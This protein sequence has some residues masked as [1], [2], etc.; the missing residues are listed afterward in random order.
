M[1]PAIIKNIRK[2]FYLCLTLVNYTKHLRGERDTRGARTL[3][4][5]SPLSPLTRKEHE[6]P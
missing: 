1:G 6:R 5:L 4:P 2:Q 3:T